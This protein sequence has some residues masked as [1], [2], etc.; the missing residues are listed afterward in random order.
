MLLTRNQMMNMMKHPVI[1]TPKL[2][3]TTSQQT[4][5][6]GQIFDKDNNVID[7]NATVSQNGRFVMH[8]KKM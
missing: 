2:D 8:P 1:A 6:T 4:V 7:I 3:S 5:N